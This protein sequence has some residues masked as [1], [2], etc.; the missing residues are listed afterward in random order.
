MNLKTNGYIVQR[1]NANTYHGVEGDNWYLNYESNNQKFEQYFN[2]HIDKSWCDELFVD[3]CTDLD[4]LES[5]ISESRKL[6]IPCRIILCETERE[7][8]R[9]VFQGESKVLGYD[10]AYAGG[11]YYSCIYN[12]I[13]FKRIP[14]LSDFSLNENGLISTQEEIKKFITRREE[15]EKTMHEQFE[16]GDFVIYKLSEVIKLRKQS[17]ET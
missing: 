3:C 11:S 2:E 9:V 4:Y 10:Y 5:Y 12:D 16:E 17:T 15:L 8:P 14:E 13:F 1:A 7:N 6:N